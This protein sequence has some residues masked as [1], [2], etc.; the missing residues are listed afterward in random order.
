MIGY[1]ICDTGKDLNAPLLPLHGDLDRLG[2]AQHWEVFWRDAQLDAAEPVKITVQRHYW[3][4]N[5]EL[6]EKLSQNRAE[7]RSCAGHCGKLNAVRD[8]DDRRSACQ[9]WSVHCARHTGLPTPC[10]HPKPDRLGSALMNTAS[11]AMG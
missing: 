7:S 3:K 10:H 9:G 11:P 5:A 8:A 6:E 1:P 2:S 4:L